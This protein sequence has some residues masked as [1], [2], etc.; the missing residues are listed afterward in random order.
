MP[1]FDLSGFSWEATRVRGSLE[2]ITGR[3]RGRPRDCEGESPDIVACSTRVWFIA[4]VGW[5][6]V[7]LSGL[8]RCV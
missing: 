8:R 3:S 5:I 6:E 7:S 2:S 4:I 1:V